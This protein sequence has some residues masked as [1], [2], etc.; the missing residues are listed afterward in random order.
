MGFSFSDNAAISVEHV[1]RERQPVA[2]IDNAVADPTRLVAAARG[3]D[4]RRIGPYYPGVR[5]PLDSPFTEG[6]CRALQPLLRG[7]F[8]VVRARWTGKSF[9]SLVA[10]PP[11]RLA[12]IQRL[13][14]FDG[15]EPDA[16]AVLYYLGPPAHG[17]TAFF[18]HRASGY[19]TMTATRFPGYQ[20]MLEKE[21]AEHGPPPAKYIGDGAPLFERTSVFS[22][23]FN[24]MLVYRGVM[25]HS[26]A[27]AADAPLSPDPARGRLT[28][29]GFLDPA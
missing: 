2:V 6:L 29:T 21:I 7:L 22:A 12:V 15:L 17:G 9:F 20:R 11:E 1:G 18:R 5:A 27:I 8:G 28:V 13:P 23:V 10:D 3:R 14:H 19:E 25:L 24:R 4:Y 16:I 26:G